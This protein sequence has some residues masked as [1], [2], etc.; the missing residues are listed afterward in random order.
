[1]FAAVIKLARRKDRAANPHAVL[2]P[3][4]IPGVWICGGLG[5]LVV[6]IGI[7]VSSS[8]PGD[9]SNKLGFEL[10]LIAGTAASILIGLILY[11]RG[12]RLL[13]LDLDQILLP[14]RL[15]SRRIGPGAWDGARRLT[16]QLEAEPRGGGF[17]VGIVCVC[18]HQILDRNQG[19]C[20]ILQ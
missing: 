3:G 6:L 8:R 10:K 12:V 7:F 2:V 18:I 11:W 16:V 9:S 19:D 5:F 20:H 1:M 17:P 14:N 13:P 4:G 15:P